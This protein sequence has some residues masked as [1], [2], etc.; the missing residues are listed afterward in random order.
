MRVA[1]DIIVVNVILIFKIFI[2]I[3]LIMMMQFMPR[4]HSWSLPPR[5]ERKLLFQRRSKHWAF[6]C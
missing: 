6:G 2:I 4:Y 1:A 5:C 3:P